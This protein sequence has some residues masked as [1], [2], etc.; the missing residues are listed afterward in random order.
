MFYREPIDLI[1]QIENSLLGQL[2]YYWE[3]YN[4]PC[5]LIFQR[6]KAENL[7]GVRVRMDNPDAASFILILVERLR[8][9]LYNNEDK[10]PINLN[11]LM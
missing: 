4:K 2:I 3:Y 7:T 8:V 9:R 10:K 6:A 11:D 5:S 1:V